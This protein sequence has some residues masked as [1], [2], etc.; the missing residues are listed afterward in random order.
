MAQKFIARFDRKGAL[1]RLSRI[2]AVCA[3]TFV[4]LCTMSLIDMLFQY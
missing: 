2:S 3:S 4:T 1:G